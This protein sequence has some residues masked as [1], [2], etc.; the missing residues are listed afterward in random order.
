VSNFWIQ[1][2]T[3]KAVDLVEPTSDMI[4]IRDIAYALSNLCR[5]SGHC[6]PFYSVAE[7]SVRVQA[8][9]PPQLKLVGLMH[10]AVEAY[11]GD[12]VA[13]IKHM[14]GIK[15]FWREM[16]DCIWRVIAAKYGLPL[17]LPAAV[18][19]ADLRMLETEKRDLGFL[20]TPRPWIDTGLEPY[21]ETF[22]T[23]SSPTAE[24]V[25]L[26]R[27]DELYTPAPGVFR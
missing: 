1:S 19:E 4:D 5:Y 7:H 17:E 10:D 3:G 21:E 15:E 9:L 22:H 8:K 23:M 20:P 16:D 14:P 2:Y 11:T 26:S 27:F 18:Q 25:F 24:S 13:P 6:R 12:L